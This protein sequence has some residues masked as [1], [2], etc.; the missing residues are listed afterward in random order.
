MS[1]YLLCFQTVLQVSD[2]FLQHVTLL[3]QEASQVSDNL[4]NVRHIQLVLDD[5]EVPG[6][7]ADR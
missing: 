3:L 7:A 2:L 6:A 4:V 1:L 5:G